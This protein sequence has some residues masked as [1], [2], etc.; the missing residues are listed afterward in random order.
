MMLLIYLSGFLCLLLVF[1]VRLISFIY[2]MWWRPIRIQ[3]QMRSQGIKGPSYKFI[4]GNNKEIMDLR[5]QVMMSSTPMELSHHDIFSRIQPHIYSWIKLYG[6]NFLIWDGPQPQLVVTEPGLIK[7]ILNNKEKS[8]PK[9]EAKFYDKKLL[10]EGLL[11]VH[12]DKWAK[13]RKLASHTFHAESLKRKIPAMITTV[14]GM[15]E[16]WRSQEGKEI[17]V[18]HE[19]MVLTSEMISR[20]AFG[21]NYL[22]GKNTIDMIQKMGSICSQNEFK[23]R[24][25]GLSELIKTSDDIESDKLEKDIRDSIVSMIK[26]REENV[27]TGEVENYGND[28]LGGLMKAY[29][30]T[31]ETQKI[32]L[33]D[34]IDEC[35]TFYFSG[36]ESTT[37]LL[38]WATLLLAT[39]LDWQ[40]KARQEVIDLFGQQSPSPDNVSKLKIMSMIINESLRLYAPV[41]SIVRETKKEVRIGK[42]KLPANMQFYIPIHALHHDP[43][44]WGEDAHL[45]KP[46]RFAEGVA[47]ATNNS[48]ASFL[49]FSLGP[50]S[51]VGYNFAATEVKVALSMILQRYKIT[52]SPAYAHAPVQLLTIRP[53]HGLQIILHPI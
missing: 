31:D 39:N 17:E 18:V 49:A 10:G 32:S 53:A 43:Q 36:Y 30:N 48:I 47:K 40:D 12:G 11:T 23:V 13:Q 21:S 5:G 24:I 50:R 27:K 8:Y 45:F 16:R 35:K 37:S 44:L 38:C 15:L 19:F 52:L 2:R 51:C 14:E 3:S 41:Y 29:H 26:K 28:Y 4:H 46:E 22:E 1:V 42:V 7:D 20:T 25:P 34:L 33:Q 9:R 6:K